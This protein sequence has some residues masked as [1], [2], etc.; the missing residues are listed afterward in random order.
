M[1]PLIKVFLVK[2][3]REPGHDPV[4]GIFYNYAEQDLIIEATNKKSALIISQLIS[5]LTF[6]GQLRRTFI[7]GEEYFSEQF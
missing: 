2:V 4:T 5:T 1:E 7:D 3:V 6:K